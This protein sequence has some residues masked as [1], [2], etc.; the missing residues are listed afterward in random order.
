MKFNNEMLISYCNEKNIKLLND[1]SNHHIR[2]ESYIEGI[3]VND[4]CE[5]QFN[6]NFR[7]LIKTGAYCQTCMTNIG[8]Y[9][10]RIL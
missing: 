3:C 5:N 1:Y 7:Q 2:R 8:N 10:D 9:V 4:A 6:K